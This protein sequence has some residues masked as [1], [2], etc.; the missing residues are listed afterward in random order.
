MIS[1][2]STDRRWKSID[3]ESEMVS[4]ERTFCRGLDALI[5]ELL[6]PM[7]DRKLID[8]RYYKHCVSSL[9]QMLRFHRSLLDKLEAAALDHHHDDD[10][11]HHHRSVAA[12]LCRTVGRRRDHFTSIYL[13]FNS[14]PNTMPCSS[15]L[16]PRSIKTRDSTTSSGRNAKVLLSLFVCCRRSEIRSVSDSSCLSM[17]NTLK[18]SHCFHGQIALN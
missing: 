18:I 15:S 1:T 14:S 6:L 10:D 11:H 12:T 9:P 5:N 13:Q 2:P 17:E 3:I 8:R 16:A 7:L 4:T